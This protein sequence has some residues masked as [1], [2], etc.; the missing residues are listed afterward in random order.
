MGLER[1][2][3]LHFSAVVV[4][5][6]CFGL[7]CSE[8]CHKRTC[9][10]VMLFRLSPWRQ[11]C[12][13]TLVHAVA[14]MKAPPVLGTHLLLVRKLGLCSSEEQ[15]S[16]YVALVGSLATWLSTCEAQ[17]QCRSGSL[18]FL[19]RSLRLQAELP[20]ARARLAMPPPSEAAACLDY[21]RFTHSPKRTG[22]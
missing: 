4:I 16:D 2:V 17:H 22:K 8:G 7:R 15:C 3:Q 18:R 20:P 10:G 9:C 1:P 12:A 14:P 11:S 21:P 19:G 13:N 5:N 6:Q